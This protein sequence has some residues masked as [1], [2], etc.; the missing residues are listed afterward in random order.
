MIFYCIAT[1]D[2]LT[3]LSQQCFLFFIAVAIPFTGPL[4]LWFM[5][6][7]VNTS[8]KT[9]YRLHASGECNIFYFLFFFFFVGSFNTTTRPCKILPTFHGCKNDNLQMKNVIFYLF[10][11]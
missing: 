9:Q 5:Y 2:I 10:L 8:G 6:G 7:T 3:K 4:V 1:A 11:L